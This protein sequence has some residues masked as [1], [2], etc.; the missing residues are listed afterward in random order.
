MWYF[1]IYYLH[2]LMMEY[3]WFIVVIIVVYTG[4]VLVR[5]EPVDNG[6]DDFRGPEFRSRKPGVLRKEFSRRR[7]GQSLLLDNFIKLHIAI[8]FYYVE[9]MATWVIMKWSHWLFRQ[10]VKQKDKTKRRH[11]LGLSSINCLWTKD[12][13]TEKPLQWSKRAE[14]SLQF[15]SKCSLITIVLWEK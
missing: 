4:T 6:R 13:Q 3:L 2:D 9:E 7:G 12:T 1:V 10:Q 14:N 15:T 5:P 8:G 11:L